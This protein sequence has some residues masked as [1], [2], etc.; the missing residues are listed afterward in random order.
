M[1]EISAFPCSIRGLQL[2]EQWPNK[3]L[4]GSGFSIAFFSET[5]SMH[6]DDL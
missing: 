4:V 2:I 3:E 5:T 1:A 6:L